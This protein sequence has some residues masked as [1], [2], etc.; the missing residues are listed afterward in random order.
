MKAVFVYKTGKNFKIV[1]N[2]ELESGSY[3]SSEPIYIL[4]LDIKKDEFIKKLFEALNYSR[5]LTE[6]EEDTYWLGKNLLK[7]LKETSFDKLYRTS[8]S[9]W[10]KLT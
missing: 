10:I 8:K 7:K 2:Y 3:I 5:K 1:T 6:D 9:F 4:P